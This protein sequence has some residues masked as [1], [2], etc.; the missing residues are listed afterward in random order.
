ML[1]NDEEQSEEPTCDVRVDDDDGLGRRQGLSAERQQR[2]EQEQEQEHQHQQRGGPLSRSPHPYNRKKPDIID[3]DEVRIQSRRPTSVTGA[4]KED[5]S[6]RPTSAT[7]AA[8]KDSNSNS[9]SNSESDP[10][11]QDVTQPENENE[12]EHEPSWRRR[13]RRS[14]SDSGTEADDESYGVLRGLPAP[15]TRQSKGLKD[16][17]GSGGLEA[18]PSPLLT[19]AFLSETDRKFSLDFGAASRRGGGGGVGGGSGA[20]GKPLETEEE[21]RAAAARFRKR[22]RRELVRRAVEVLLVLAVGG[23]TLRQKHVWAASR[24]LGRELSVFSIIITVLVALYPIR[25]ILSSR[26]S[27][28][29]WRGLGKRIRI[30]SAFDPAP[31]LYAPFLPVF[32]ALSVLPVNRDALLPN[33]ILSLSTLPPNLIP[34]ATPANGNSVVHWFISL[35]PLAASKNTNFLTSTPHALSDLQTRPLQGLEADL[36]VFL[37]PLHQAMLPVLSYLTTT[38]LLPAELQL[39]SVSLINILLLSSSPQAVILQALLLGGGISIFVLCGHVLRWIVALA[40]IP[41][42]RFKHAGR[43]IKARTAFLN[44]LKPSPSRMKGMRL[45]NVGGEQSD[46]DDDNA[47]GDGSSLQGLARVRPSP[48]YTHPD[49]QAMA[50]GGING[51]GI[52]VDQAGHEQLSAPTLRVQA[53]S[54]VR[55]SQPSQARVGSGPTPRRKRRASSTV[56]SYLS[57]TSVEAKTRKWLYAGYVYATVCVIVL[58]G[59]RSYVQEYALYGNEPVGWAIGYLFGHLDGPRLFIVERNLEKWISLPSRRGDDS[60]GPTQSCHLGWVE[61]LRRDTLGE[62]NTRLVVCVYYLGVLV[63]GIAIVLRLSSAVEVDTRRKVFHGMMVAMFLPT[64]YVDPAFASLALILVLA[65]FLLLDLFRASQLPPVSKPLAYFLTPYVDGR[66]LRGPV[67]VSHIF[68]LIGCAIPLWLSLAGIDRAGEGPWKGWDVTVREVGML[69]GV[70]CVGMGD[71]AASLIG[72]RFGRTKWL[73]SGG[74]SIEGSAAFAIAVV[75]GLCSAKLWLTVGGWATDS[76]PQDRWPLTLGKATLAACGASL[77]EAV[78]TGGNDN[79]IVPVVLWLLVRALS[80]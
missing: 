57:L 36:L 18:F 72:R 49:T 25:I 13:R 22:R 6:R 53:L 44:A 38:S 68:L 9:N 79:V 32:A 75:V 8:A 37:Y 42:W 67:V 61:H 51:L 63:V 31:L 52:S 80:I 43:I 26:S 24:G 17:R 73:W 78:L 62:A 21:I 47:N 2:Q 46:G 77:T 27:A 48:K 39:L 3:R 60:G 19:P 34:M 29:S 65:I 40:R 30:P 5:I 66:D 59:I 50:D 14:L 71:A 12:H 7:G 35:L 20:R 54:D 56:Q 58:V 64:L 23:L 55:R 15:P 74:K 1:Y 76:G 10:D 33:L 11:S 28:V 41:Q 16:A 70:V 69:S 45:G 4:A